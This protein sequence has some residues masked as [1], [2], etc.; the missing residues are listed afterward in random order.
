MAEITPYTAGW[1][2]GADPWASCYGPDLH[3]AEDAGRFDVSPAWHAWM[4]AEAA[5]GFAAS[6][7]AEEVRDHAVG[8]ANVFRERLD[9]APSNSA[10]VTWPD[11]DGIE[12]AALSRAGITASGRAGRARV[13]FHLWNDDEDVDLA[14]TTLGR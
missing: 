2:S 1:Y 8:L 6:L 4:G 9:L 14:A 3:L 11:A 5:L 7:D 10:I 12:L 13:A